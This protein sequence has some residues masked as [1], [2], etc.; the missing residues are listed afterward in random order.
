MDSSNSSPLHSSREEFP[1]VKEEAEDYDVTKDDLH[2]TEQEDAALS[3]NLHDFLEDENYFENFDYCDQASFET[4]S[5]SG[6]EFEN[7]S[8][9]IVE[10]DEPFKPLASDSK[11][12]S[13]PDLSQRP[14][15]KTSRRRIRKKL[16]FSRGYFT[17]SAKRK[18]K[19]AQDIIKWI[20][21]TRNQFKCCAIHQELTTSKNAP[22]TP[23]NKKPRQWN[24]K[25]KKYKQQTPN[26]L[27]TKRQIRRMIRKIRD[28]QIEQIRFCRGENMFLKGKMFHSVL[29]QEDL[30]EE[31]RWILEDQTSAQ[32]ETF[33]AEWKWNLEE[34]EKVED[35]FDDWKWNIETDIG[36]DLEIKAISQEQQAE[37]FFSDWIWNF[38]EFIEIEE[39][40]N[41]WKKNI[42]SSDNWKFWQHFGSKEEIMNNTEEILEVLKRMDIDDDCIDWTMWEFWNMFGSVSEILNNSE[43]VELATCHHHQEDAD[44]NDFDDISIRDVNNNVSDEE[45]MENIDIVVNFD[46]DISTDSGEYSDTEINDSDTE[47][48]DSETDYDE[49]MEDFENDNEQEQAWQQWRFWKEIGT[50]KEILENNTDLMVFGCFEEFV[51]VANEEFLKVVTFFIFKIHEKQFK[52]S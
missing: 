17:C 51:W 44:N 8:G 30:F 43:T 50:V 12:K 9:T 24:D 32:S 16:G 40:F 46:D 45:E 25:S 5:L 49:N 34:Y 42:L 39:K 11:A 37:D 28:I 23:P 52:N 35:I 20:K 26:L 36:D 3:S 1:L 33:F 2:C 21:G 22:N 13:Y 4:V 6:D 14:P 19:N 38:N 18:S 15:A 29:S 41:T 27:K 31:W 7:D 47:I 10:T 48:N